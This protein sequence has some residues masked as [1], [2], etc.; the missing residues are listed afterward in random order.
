MVIEVHAAGV[1]YKKQS[2]QVMFKFIF[3]KKNKNKFRSIL[4]INYS[5]GYPKRM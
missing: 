1:K 2:L 4:G 5:I 3:A